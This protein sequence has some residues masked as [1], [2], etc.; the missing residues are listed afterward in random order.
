MAMNNSSALERAEE[1]FIAIFV[2]HKKIFST[3]SALTYKDRNKNSSA[4]QHADRIL[5]ENSKKKFL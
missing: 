4:F 2:L 1:I 5:I 3:S